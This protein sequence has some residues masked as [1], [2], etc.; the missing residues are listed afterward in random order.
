MVLFFHLTRSS[1]IQPRVTEREWQNERNRENLT[2]DVGTKI[3][4]GK[5]NKNNKSLFFNGNGFPQ[6]CFFQR[7]QLLTRPNI[8]TLNHE[9]VK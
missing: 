9:A 2:R 8:L 5:F 7:K 4:R 1:S 6:L 3:A